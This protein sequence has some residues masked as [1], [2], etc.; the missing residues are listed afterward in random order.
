MRVPRVPYTQSGAYARVGRGAGTWTC[1]EGFD[2]ETTQE[3]TQTPQGDKIRK[4]VN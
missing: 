3:R 4:T 2:A 1:P